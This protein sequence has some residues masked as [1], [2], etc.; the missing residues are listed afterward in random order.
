MLEKQSFG[1]TMRKLHK[2]SKA[3]GFYTTDLFYTGASKS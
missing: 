2:F 3:T 1:R